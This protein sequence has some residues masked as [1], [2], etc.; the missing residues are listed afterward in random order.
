MYSQPVITYFVFG[1]MKLP[2]SFAY[3]LQPATS[4]R[5]EC[6][7]T[8]IVVLLVSSA[9]CIYLAPLAMPMGY[10]WLSNAIS[11]SAAQGLR[12]TW[13]ARLGFI[14]F[15][16]GVLWLV[17]ARKTTWARGVH[18]M[19]LCFAVFMLGTAAFS[20]KPWLDDIAFDPVEDFL[21]SL[22]ATGMGFAFAFGV[23]VRF[24]QRDNND[25]LQ[26]SFDLLAIIAATV[27]SPIGV[28]MPGIAGLLQR[29]MFAVAYLWFIHEALSPKLNSQLNSQCGS[30]QNAPGDVK[31]RLA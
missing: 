22:T 31:K 16:L 18:W 21:H 4:S 2:E 7:R 26:K 3:I 29:L 15:G 23:V 27:L 17:L 10:S 19:Q 24:L 13:I 20:H 9:I 14:L 12:H 6:T 25:K 1:A 30:Q 5:R 28:A 8:G 11:E